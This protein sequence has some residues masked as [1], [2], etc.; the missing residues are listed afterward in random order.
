MEIP[1][2]YW[3]SRWEGYPI[4]LTKNCESC[5]YHRVIEAFEVCGF[6]VAWK[7]LVKSANMTSCGKLK[8]PGTERTRS[9]K[10]LDKLIASQ[11]SKSSEYSNK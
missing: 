6:G 4:N 9:V 8:W 2:R 11:Q 3:V 5:P 1:R 10:F 7:E